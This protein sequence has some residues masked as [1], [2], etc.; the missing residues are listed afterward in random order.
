MLVLSNISVS[1]TGMAL[2]IYIAFFSLADSECHNIKHF[3]VNAS[4]KT[5]R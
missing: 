2:Y 3:V 4:T 1:W 5:I